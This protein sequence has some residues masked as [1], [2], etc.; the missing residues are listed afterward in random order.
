M[1]AVLD[2]LAVGA[3]ATAVILVALILAFWN[4]RP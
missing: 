4:T 1:T 3:I 2:G